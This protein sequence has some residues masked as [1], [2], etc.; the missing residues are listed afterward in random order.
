MD[1]LDHEVLVSALLRRL[2]VPVDMSA[3]HLNFI[4]VE[5][6]EVRL[7]R[8]KS[9]GLQ[10]VYVIDVPCVL[11]HCRYVRCQES[12][13]VSHSYDHRAVL[14]GC[15]YLAR[16]VLKHQSQSVGA[17]YTHHHPVDGVDRSYLVF[18]V[19]IIDQ[20]DDH[21]G[22]CRAVERIAVAYELGFKLFIV[23][24]DT[25]VYADDF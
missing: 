5:V 14:S 8:Q 13:A 3:L 2:G 24:D 9:H 15:I 16:I 6:K 12:L 1:L 7:A 23:L 11:E 25:V 20:L 21:F 10:I 22:I 19:V 4:A 18:L 17:A